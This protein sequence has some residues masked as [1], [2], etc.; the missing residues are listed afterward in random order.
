MVNS[1]IV[2]VVRA[3]KNFKALRP[4]EASRKNCVEQLK[5][6]L[7][8]YYGYNSFLIGTLVEVTL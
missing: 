6:D 8:S 7:G 4:K 3:L 5:A 2:S 1:F